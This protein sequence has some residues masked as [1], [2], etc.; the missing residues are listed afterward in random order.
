MWTFMYEK[1]NDA[2]NMSR[3]AKYV[4]V[5]FGWFFRRLWYGSGG[6][7]CFNLLSHFNET[8]AMFLYN[9]DSAFVLVEFVNDTTIPNVCNC[10]HTEGRYHS[11]CYGSN[12]C[13]VK[14]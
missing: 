4:S 9:Y 3:M 5:S 14:S 12:Y 1:K 2:S 6:N 8:V 10:L 11:T 7:Q 13:L